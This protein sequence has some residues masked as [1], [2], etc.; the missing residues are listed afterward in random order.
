M[1]L[2][3]GKIIYFNQAKLA[4]DY[5][6]SLNFQCPD[7]ANPADFFMNTMSIENVERVRAQGG[8][9]Q[10]VSKSEILEEYSKKI[11][12]LHQSYEASKLKNDYTYKSPEAERI[13]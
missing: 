12:F 10:N 13:Q 11:D 9:N 5:F 2:A 8:E 7:D 6:A 3:Q 4:V 1:L